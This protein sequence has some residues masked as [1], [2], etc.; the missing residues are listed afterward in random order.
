MPQSE[1]IEL[2]V[3]H[4]VRRALITVPGD[5]HLW[6]PLPAFVVLCDNGIDQGKVS[7]PFYSASEEWASANAAASGP[8][9]TNP[10]NGVRPVGPDGQPLGALEH[11][12]AVVIYV[13]G[14]PLL[15]GSGQTS[16]T[17]NSGDPAGSVS[18][19]GNTLVAN[20]LAVV[21]AALGYTQNRLTNA[22][23]SKL[24][25]AKGTPAYLLTPESF[26]ACRIYAMGF[27]NAGFMALFLAGE[28]SVAPMQNPVETPGKPTVFALGGV[29]S[30]AGMVGGFRQGGTTIASP[31]PGDPDVQTPEVNNS[32]VTPGNKLSVLLINGGLD[33]ETGGEAGTLHGALGYFG[34]QNLYVPALTSVD[35]AIAPDSL[36]AFARVGWDAAAQALLA[37]WD[38]TMPYTAAVWANHL[39]LLTG[40][41][42]SWDARAV[43]DAR[44]G[45]SGGAASALPNLPFIEVPSGVTPGTEEAELA[46]HVNLAAK[47]WHENN[48]G[49]TFTYLFIPEMGH[50]LNVELG[51]DVISSVA[52]WVELI[53]TWAAIESERRENT[54]FA[55]PLV[56]VA[57]GG[58]VGPPGFPFAV[59]GANDGRQT[60]DDGER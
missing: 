31:P 33:T 55:C 2:V 60:I 42:A 29:I 4:T 25:F 58:G 52:S 47:L 53:F 32:P 37:R 27:S 1:A 34:I 8:E 54:P 15:G 22:L 6:V 21:A 40:G 48:L 7:Y 39:G 57:I 14:L 46:M 41:G 28:D 17:W 35:L 59:F 3:G 56:V 12:R 30:I 38:Y 24:G 26:D 20:E 5:W 50:S 36:L 43:Y 49:F 19:S 16:L 23:A 10:K 44:S 51:L 13:Q 11:R 45:A 18:E 9:L